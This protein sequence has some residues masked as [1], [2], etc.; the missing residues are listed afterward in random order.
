[1]HVRSIFSLLA[2]FSCV[3]IMR[4][5]V[6]AV[7][8]ILLGALTCACADSIV[9][10]TV[11]QEANTVKFD[12]QN[13]QAPGLSVEIMQALEAADPSI[14]FSG[15]DQFYPL[16]RVVSEMDQGKIDIFI[17]LVKSPGRADK[18]R[19]IA[20]P[21]LYV[22]QD[23]VAV[24]ANDPVVVSNFDDI[25]KLK[26]EG[27]IGVP[28]GS[29]LAD[30]LQGVGGLNIDDG[31]VSLIS[32]LKKLNLG[33]V[34]FVYS[35]GAVLRKTIDDLQLQGQIKVLPAVLHEESLQIAVSRSLDPAKL[36]RLQAALDEIAR[37]GELG[38]LRT[39]Y[40]VK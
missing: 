32:T 5:F 16:K 33:R 21:I 19:F 25:R 15:T 6:V 20:S 36:A 40:Q 3:P 34:R 30:Y 38:R 28:Q 26:A 7:G 23:Q 24:R 10:K 27:V 35:G 14:H 13:A 12:P 17:G 2:V 9:Y 11:S 22:Q 31:A 8:W 37:N 18:L 1:V 39:K 29:I 4:P